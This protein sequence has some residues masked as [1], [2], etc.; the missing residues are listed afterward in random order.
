MSEANYQMVTNI[1][2]VISF[3]GPEKR[4]HALR[5]EE[6]ERIINRVEQ[7]VEEEQ[8]GMQYT[9]G[10]KVSVISGAFEGMEGVVEE[11]DT[12]NRR[13]KVMVK[14][15]G[16]STPLELDYIQVNPV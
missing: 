3:L 10:M 16:R 9:V 2:R 8:K 5:D 11:V 1:N 12:D 13:L 6:I 15:F 14:I 7:K 4:P